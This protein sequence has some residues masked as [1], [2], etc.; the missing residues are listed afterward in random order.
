MNNRVHV[1]TVVIW[2]GNLKHRI[3]I[4]ITFTLFLKTLLL[5]KF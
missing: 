2:Y 4:E 5:L 3:D 1:T